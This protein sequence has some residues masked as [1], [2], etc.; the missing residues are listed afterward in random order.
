M[1]C[2]T[3]L[4]GA[5][6][7]V[8]SVLP[9]IQAQTL[10]DVIVRHIRDHG[11]MTISTFMAMALGH[12][13]FG[14]YMHR[15]PFGRAGDFITA[16]EIS[17]LF[18]EM[19]G[20]WLADLWLRMDRPNPFLLVEAGPGRGTLMADIMRATV[21]VDGFHAAARIHLVE[22]SPNLKIVQS[23]N[24]NGFAPRWHDSIDTI[25]DDAP[26]LFVA[27]EFLD[28]LPIHQLVHT[29]AGWAERMIGVNDDGDL[30]FGLA[31]A[32]ASLVTCVP[33]GLKNDT[34]NIFE[35]APARTGFTQL[36]S[37]RI[38]H[39]GGAALFIDYGHARPGMGDTL[40]A[41]KNHKFVNLFD[42]PGAADVT[43]HVDFSAIASAA[44]A[45]NVH[46]TAIVEQWQFLELM[47][48]RLRAD[49]LMASANGA[50]AD[51]IRSGL[52]RLIAPDQMGGL[53]KVV[54]L[55]NHQTPIPSGFTE[56]T[57]L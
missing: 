45:H 57:P 30:I 43:S 29:D 47:G 10:H 23:E 4:N 46:A 49:K 25:P 31:P 28:A 14:Y 39:Q 34:G 16:P 5:F 2:F 52:E 11:P 55:Y 3:P 26:I 15:D 6:G 21:R 56:D 54:A 18:G 42:D 53:F 41:M 24:L 22:T 8:D 48:I 9:S 32:D 33:A 27:N 1:L 36:L 35:V 12:P 20:V 38:A 44:T 13:Q 40:Q 17:Q 37:E 50:Q 51:T 19:I 7:M